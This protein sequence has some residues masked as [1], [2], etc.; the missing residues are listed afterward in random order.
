MKF[1]D[2]M[3]KSDDCLELFKTKTMRVLV[4]YLWENSREYFI[5]HYFLPF[6]CIGNLPLFV[7]ALELNWIEGDAGIMT[8]VVYY[9]TLMVFLFGTAKSAR[10]E[11]REIKAKKLSKYFR[12]R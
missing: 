7:L 2:K 6:I 4:N 8:W 10:E 12:D 5:Y 11:I 9:I 1:L 3:C